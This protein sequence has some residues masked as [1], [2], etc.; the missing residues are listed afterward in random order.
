MANI[1]TQPTDTKSLIADITQLKKTQ[2]SRYTRQDSDVG[3]YLLEEFVWQ[4]KAGK[5]YS[6]A[7]NITLNDARTYADKV[8]AT[9]GTADRQVDITCFDN[10]D[11]TDWGQIAEDFCKFVIQRAEENLTILGEYPYEDAENWYGCIRG[12][13]AAR[14]LLKSGG[15]LWY[16]ELMPIDPRQLAWRNDGLGTALCSINSVMTKQDIALQFQTNIK[17]ESAV[18]DDIWTHTENIII[19]NGKDELRRVQHGL[20]Y[21]PVIIVPCPTTPLIAGRAD[22]IKYQYESIYYAVRFLYEALNKQATAWA[23]SNMMSI[24]PPMQFV[25][26]DGRKSKSP[27]YG[28][29]AIMNLRLGEEYKAMP[30]KDVSISHQAFFGQLMARIQR[31]TMSNIDYGELSQELS[32]LAIKRLE[33]KN[34]QIINPRLKAKRELTKR[35]YKAFID[36]FLAGGYKTDLVEGTGI[37]LDWKPSDLSKRFSIF[38]NY[39]TVSPE[40]DVANLNI[41]QNYQAIGLDEKTIM[42]KLNIENPDE[43]RMQRRRD[44]ASKEVLTIRRYD[45]AIAY[46]S[47]KDGK[48]P[49]NI[50][51]ATFALAEIGMQLDPATGEITPIQQA[52]PTGGTP[53]PT[54]AE[55]QGSLPNLMNQQS[56][57]NA[58]VP[59]LAPQTM[60]NNTNRVATQENARKSA[61]PPFV[62]GQ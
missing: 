31:A 53:T 48:D 25:S 62:G 57:P 43:V 45:E 23:S 20:P 40:V 59:Q 28:I 29:R 38:V 8:I 18:I 37:K 52:L 61:N 6:G 19:M 32:A 12:I 21:N 54:P 36:Q 35:V 26:K 51:R 39:L 7:E 2:E 30:I 41:A 13:M 58:V 56:V 47:G 17:Q 22:A 10:T 44:E 5:E 16:P 24:F 34:D 60:V 42:K 33:A 1:Q 50:I 55:P 11:E 3:Y 4:D 14:P 49:H 46:I 27:P 15:G 9:L